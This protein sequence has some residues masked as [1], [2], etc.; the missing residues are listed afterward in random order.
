MITRDRQALIFAKGATPKASDDEVVRSKPQFRR[1]FEVEIQRKIAIWK[2]AS[3]TNS[4]SKEST[5]DDITISTYDD[6]ESDHFVV[7]RLRRRTASRSDH[8][9]VGRLRRRTPSAVICRAES[10]GTGFDAVPLA[11]ER[12]VPKKRRG[13]SPQRFVRIVF[14]NWFES[15]L[16]RLWSDAL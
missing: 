11:A 9:V 1:R 2:A 3:L 6:F 16:T 4:I 12:P 10:S 5:S 14:N 15:D 13:R 7:G 8:F